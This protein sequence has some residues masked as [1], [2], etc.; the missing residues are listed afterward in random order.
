[1]Y[2]AGRTQLRR[3]LGR[4]LGRDA[5]SIEFTYGTYG[6]PLLKDGP[7][8]NLSHSGGRAVLAVCEQTD[9]GLD[10]EKIRPIENAVARHHFSPAE[11]AKL[12]ALPNSE[13][14]QGFF[15]CWTRKEAVLKMLGH[16][17]HM[18]LDSFDVT[19]SPDV[20]PQVTRIEGDDPSR[21]SLFHL[22]PCAG[23]VGA[24]ALRDVLGSTKLVWRQGESAGHLY[25]RHSKI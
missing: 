18:P 23:W 22:E 16:G 7:G 3:I 11:Y 15:R 21:W 9:P 24:L 1:M 17:L 6:K 20:S 14:L 8:F 12:S 4:Y 25:S 13:W 19:L 5:N 10:I 2:I